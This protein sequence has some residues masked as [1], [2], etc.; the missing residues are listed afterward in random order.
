MTSST[1]VECRGLV[2]F[3]KENQWHR[4]FH[5]EL[6]L[7]SVDQPTVAYEDNTASIT[8][9]SD[10][11]TPHKKSKHFGIEWSFFKESVEFGEI[12]PIFVHTNQQPADMLTKSLLSNKFVEFRDMVMGD[13]VLQDFFTSNPMVTHFCM[14]VPKPP[15]V[16]SQVSNLDDVGL[17]L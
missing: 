4:Q 5:N 6:N 15:P 9:S 14:K 7:F 2:Q 8:L 10:L 17:P 12:T 16:E 1:E 11:G 13:S 3:G